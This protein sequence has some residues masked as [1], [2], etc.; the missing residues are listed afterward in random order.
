MLRPLLILLLS[1]FVLAGCQRAPH[2]APAK[3]ASS[4]TSKTSPPTATHASE[5]RLR[6]VV[7]DPL[8]APLSCACLP[9]VGQRRYERL[10]QFVEQSLG[11]PVE[12][13][14][15]E[16]LELAYGRSGRDVQFVIGSRSVVQADGATTSTLLQPVAQLTDRRGS[17]ELRGSF[18]VS[19]NHSA[20]SVADL[21][22]GRII[23]GPAD[24]AETHSAAKQAL[25]D[26]GLLDECQIETG[27]SIETGVFAVSDGNADATVV[28]EFL[29]PMLEACG[30]IEP[31]SLRLVG[32][33]AAVPFVTLFSTELASPADMLAVR[34]TLTEFNAKPELLELL[35]S[36]D[37]FVFLTEDAAQ[38]TL[39]KSQVKSEGWIDWRG[40]HRAGISVHVPRTLPRE[41]RSLWKSPLTGPALA[42]IAATT[43][44]V[45]V[46]D[47]DVELTKDILRCFRAADGKAIW[48]IEYPSQAKLDYTSAPRATPVI[49]DDLVY[50]QGALGDLHCVEIS[51]GRIVWKRNFVTD[52]DAELL[53]WGFSVPPLVV[54]DKLIVAPGAPDASI[55]ALNRKTG[56]TLWK[57]P[58]HAAAYAAFV[59]AKVEGQHQIIGYDS[60]GLGGWN[61]DTGKR[62]WHVTPPGQVDFNV[63]TPLLHGGDVL[64]ATENNA[65]RRYAFANGKL[66][67]D[68]IAINEDLA[69][70]TC[71]PVIWNNLLFGAAYG[72][73]FCL[74]VAAH[75]K[76]VWTV[77]DDMFH[78]HTNL[79]AGNDHVLLWTTTGDLLL[80]RAADKYDI[81]KHLRPFGDA[82]VES[83]SHPA[84]LPGRLYLR[85]ARELICLD[86]D[87][88]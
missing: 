9:G 52:F 74:D 81:V 20:Q 66:A 1:S 82:E 71:T 7:M 31:D 35:E 8:A 11:R 80:M 37:G 60:A 18:V 33:T 36:R 24:Q 27:S 54:D 68:P 56:K 17:V 32:Q 70:D 13:I 45:V 77:R 16:S 12:L 83:M 5:Q 43:E 86:I 58:G 44:F 84:I 39:E 22:G 48:T 85:S 28:P 49:V 69:P 38:A 21:R 29:L 47:K 41:P 65:T 88:T 14:F 10:A 42:G 40:P 57:T 4:S 30:K 64:V 87:E 75:L 19:K 62:L 50:F 23:L 79:I 55:V 78:E 46:A 59:L 53:T 2:A 6:I 72:E 3:S 51:T 73:L 67:T 34:K 26:A 25:N 63:G 76:T 15:D 61:V